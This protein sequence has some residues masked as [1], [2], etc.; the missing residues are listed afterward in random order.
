M[1]YKLTLNMAS[2]SLMLDNVATHQVTFYYILIP[3]Y[4]L[5]YTNNEWSHYYM[6][7][8]NFK[9]LSVELTTSAPCYAV[10][11]FNQI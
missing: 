8:V 9:M 4:P 6:R 7:Y 5:F 2:I 3:S 10:Y 11:D 1:Y